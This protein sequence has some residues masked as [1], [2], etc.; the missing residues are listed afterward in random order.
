MPCPGLLSPYTK[1]PEPY[2]KDPPGTDPDSQEYK[3]P[4]R[5]TFI[6]VYAV[7]FIFLYFSYM[8]PFVS[9]MEQGGDG[10]S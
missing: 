1:L 7:L 4:L 8:R 5:L 6:L 10:L 3:L 2:P 9:S